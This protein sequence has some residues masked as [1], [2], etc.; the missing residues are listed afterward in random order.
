MNWQAIF[1]FVLLVVFLLAEAG[2]VS[3]VSIWFA[4][5]SLVAMIAA[6]L[7]AQLWLQVVLFLV[8]SAGLLAAFWPFVKRV[9]N[10]H[11]TATNLDRV[12]G[13]QGYVT[14]PVDNLS[15]TGTV[16]LDGMEWTARSTNGALIPSGT[17]VR[18][19]RIEGVKVFVTVVTEA[20]AHTV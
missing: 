15:G 8:V 4:A 9:L 7:G 3:V 13:S 2:T 5:G 17:L 6:A 18:V 10:N 20:A 12:I 16:K 14:A 1:W 11:H 19:D